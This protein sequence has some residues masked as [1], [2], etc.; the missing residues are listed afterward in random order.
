MSMNAP[1]PVSLPPAN[2]RAPPAGNTDGKSKQLAK[3]K[4]AASL[5]KAVKVTKALKKPSAGAQC[6][7]ADDEFAAKMRL[8][9]PTKPLPP[10][11]RAALEQ[12]G[13]DPHSVELLGMVDKETL[14]NLT[15][16]FGDEDSRLARLRS[17]GSCE[18]TVSVSANKQDGRRYVVHG[19]TGDGKS[20]AG[21]WTYE[22]KEADLE[23][24]ATRKLLEDVPDDGSNFFDRAR[25]NQA[26]CRHH[27]ND[28]FQRRD[29]DS[30]ESGIVPHANS[31]AEETEHGRAHG[32]ATLR[33]IR[34]NSLSA[35]MTPSDGGT[36]QRTGRNSWS[37]GT[38]PSDTPSDEIRRRGAVISPAR[39]QS[40]APAAVRLHSCEAVNNIRSLL[41][42]RV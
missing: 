25:T 7:E 38:T 28:L 8:L 22:P 13:W 6:E 31:P 24:E 32:S 27:V 37:A 33:L 14:S 20:V 40:P 3:M 5:L 39:A 18:E 21:T 26:H 36:A 29:S 1:R 42:V 34:R 2:G 11:T 17:G 41:K 19:Q 23:Q 10:K 12:A 4:S 30:S 16:T 15:R 9:N 35:G